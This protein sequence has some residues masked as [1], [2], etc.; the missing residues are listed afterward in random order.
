MTVN[1][2]L[3]VGA[4]TVCAHRPH[5]IPTT[6]SAVAP[7]TRERGASPSP[8]SRLVG[9]RFHTREVIEY[10]AQTRRPVS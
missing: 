1:A 10:D 6:M 5:G 7:R 2:D 4:T 8:P 9:G 3:K